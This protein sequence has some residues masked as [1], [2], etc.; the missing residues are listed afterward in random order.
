MFVL[1]M[2]IVYGCAWES[3]YQILNNTVFQQVRLE[4]NP[5]LQWHN[6]VSGI[7]G[8]TIVVNLLSF[9][10]ICFLGTN[11]RQVIIILFSNSLTYNTS[12][13]LLTA[14]EVLTRLNAFIFCTLSYYQCHLLKICIKFK[15]SGI[16]K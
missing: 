15:Y 2:K 6:F 10:S 7:Q 13:Y 5:H 14:L 16:N 11:S 9:S 3:L 1:P 12:A 8:R 4:R